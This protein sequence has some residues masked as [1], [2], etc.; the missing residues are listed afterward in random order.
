MG[1][2]YAV[3][4]QLNTKQLQMDT[5]NIFRVCSL[6]TRLYYDLYADPEQLALLNRC[7]HLLFDAGADPTLCYDPF[8]G[9]SS[10]VDNILQCGTMVSITTL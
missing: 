5:A 1:R 9:E 6:N 3:G 4:C 7:R 2:R 8:L 10:F